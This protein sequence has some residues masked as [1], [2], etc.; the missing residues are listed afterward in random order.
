MMSEGKCFE[1]DHAHS[2]LILKQYILQSQSHVKLL[3]RMIRLLDLSSARP[4][5]CKNTHLLLH[6]AFTRQSY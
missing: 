2:Y 1:G 6:S 4:A 5:S 3:M